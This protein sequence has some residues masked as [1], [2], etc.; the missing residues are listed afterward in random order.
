MITKQTPRKN[1][2]PVWFPLDSYGIRKRLVCPPEGL[3]ISNESHESGGES[4]PIQFRALSARSGG[5]DEG[6]ELRDEVGR[7]VGDHYELVHSYNWSGPNGLRGM[8][9]VDH[10]RADVYVC[11]ETGRQFTEDHFIETTERRSY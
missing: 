3:D 2:K 6:T 7:G 4:S 8:S 10:W 1:R 9:L 5:E 11:K